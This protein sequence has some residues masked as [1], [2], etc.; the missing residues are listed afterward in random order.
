MKNKKMIP[1]DYFD[2]QEFIVHKPNKN[3][4]QGILGPNPSPDQ[5]LKFELC[6]YITFLIDK[7]GLSL[8]EAK[9][10]TGVDTS[11]L[12]R[13]KNHHLHRFTIDRLIKICS[14]LDTENHLVAVLKNTCKK[15]GKLSA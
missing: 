15:I 3:L 10:T 1:D 9:E 8:N 12:S 4:I 6:S 11:D 13:I 7:K 2:H 14:S 5:I